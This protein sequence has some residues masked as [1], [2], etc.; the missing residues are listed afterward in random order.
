MEWKVNENT[1]EAEFEWHRGT[2]P[3]PYGTIEIDWYG[4]GKKLKIRKS[5]SA[6]IAWEIWDRTMTKI[7]D[8]DKLKFSA[9]Y[10]EFLYP[11]GPSLGLSIYMPWSGKHRYSM[12]DIMLDYEDYYSKNVLISAHSKYIKIADAYDDTLAE[13]ENFINGKLP[14]IIEEQQLAED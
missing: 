8:N 12:D 4:L 9:S 6:D 10:T 5:E 13:I 7:K 11:H 3:V 2:I 1:I 14:E